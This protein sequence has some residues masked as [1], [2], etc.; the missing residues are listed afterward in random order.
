MPISY[1]E[2][3]AWVSRS[4]SASQHPAGLMNGCSPDLRIGGYDSFNTGELLLM[5]FWL[6]PRPGNVPVPP[7][8]P[9]TG[10][11]A[12]IGLEVTWAQD[13]VK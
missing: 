2:H 10:A 4:V 8:Q 1:P 6:G 3:V 5:V 9:G 7:P 12:V 13:E 11:P